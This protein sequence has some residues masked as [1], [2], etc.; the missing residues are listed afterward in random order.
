[1]HHKRLY[2]NLFVCFLFWYVCL[3]FW[4]GVDTTAKQIR[5]H[6]KNSKTEY[7]NFNQDEEDIK[8]LNGESVKNVDDFLYLGSW[9][10]C[11]SKDV[12]VRL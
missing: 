4:S 8:A 1:M 11:C 3:F 10:D 7:I 5:L 12:N 9:I 2:R 6:I